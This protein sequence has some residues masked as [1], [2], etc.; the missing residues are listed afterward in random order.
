MK[1]DDFV[2]EHHLPDAFVTSA[3]K[4]YLPFADWVED[5][6]AE[7]S[8]QTFV[9]GINGAQGTGKSTLA[10][11]VQDYLASEFARRV[12]VLSI[13]DIYLTRERRQ[14]LS[15]RVHPLLRTRGV[16]GTHDIELGVSTLERLQLLQANESMRIPRFDKSRDDRCPQDDWPSVEGPIDLVIFEGWCVGSKACPDDELLEPINT[17]EEAA[18]AEGKWRSYVNDRLRQDYVRLFE[19]LDALLFLQ[20]PDF[21]VVLE[22]RLQQERELRVSANKGASGI[23]SDEQVAKFV[24]HYERITRRNNEILPGFADVVIELNRKHEA[25]SLRCDRLSR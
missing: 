25:T 9:L 10:Q 20:A 7:Q 11:L 12:V 5:R 19:L 21:D 14:R 2:R 24:Q 16:P 4:Y 3:R 15:E 23:M 1:L 13:D 17:L 22:W 8:G 6:L 18:D